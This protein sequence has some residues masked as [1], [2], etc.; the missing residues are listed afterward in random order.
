[1]VGTYD[2]ELIGHGVAGVGD[3]DGDQIL[4]WVVGSG[5]T[6]SKREGAAWVR[7]GLLEGDHVLTLKGANA[8]GP[9]K[10]AHLGRRVSPLGDLNGDG[11]ADVSIGGIH[12]GEENTMQGGFSILWGGGDLQDLST[13]TA[14]GYMEHAGWDVAAAGDVDGDGEEEILVGAPYRRSGDSTDE[15]GFPY[16][17][18]RV[19]LIEAPQVEE[20]D[21][22][23]NATAII[24]GS[25]SWSFLGQC[26]DGIGDINGDG[27]DDIMIGVPG[28]TS[29]DPTDPAEG[30]VDL[31]LGPITGSLSDEDADYSWEG[32]SPGDYL[33]YEIASGEDLDG[34]G[35]V[36]VAIGAYKSSAV[37][38]DGGS[39]WIL[40][41]AELEMIATLDGVLEEGRAGAALDLLA[42]GDDPGSLLIGVPTSSS[43]DVHRSGAIHILHGPLSGSQ[44]LGADSRVEGT[45][46]DGRFGSSVAGAG[47]LDGDGIEEVLVGTPGSYA[48]ELR[49]GAVYL[50]LGSALP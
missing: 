3:M 16:S 45:E 20:S 25:V 15:Q 36:D 47:D 40:S 1:M 34:D 32:D 10:I 6:G 13:F 21:L 12:L 49:T 42:N 17:P 8:V 41:G 28:H 35:V 24:E 2:N 7:S 29:D 4:D 31:F 37:A 11:L 18:G 46:I 39:V 19:Y 38:R 48:G 44:Q 23:S 22:E 9:Q 26:A 5:A 33:G 43:A 30:R 27:F 50:L 14:D